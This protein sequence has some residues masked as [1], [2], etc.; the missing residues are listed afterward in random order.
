[1]YQR[2]DCIE[3]ELQMFSQ[4]FEFLSG[5]NQPMGCP[6]NWIERLESLYSTWKPKV[7]Y[8]YAFLSLE[9]DG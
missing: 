4:Y 6:G 1:M 9:N 2:T 7:F 8:D 3:S 5:F